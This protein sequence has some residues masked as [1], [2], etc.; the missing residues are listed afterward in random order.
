MSDSIQESA[1][2]TERKRHMADLL[3]NVKEAL[4]RRQ[5]V[6]R[7]TGLGRTAIFERLNPR[8]KYHDPSFPRPV[9][10]GGGGNSTRY[11]ASEVDTWVKAKIEASRRKEQ[12]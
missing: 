5:D 10:I 2:R 7:L 8:S 6:E 11:V 4:L 1:F 9:Q 12:A 3:S